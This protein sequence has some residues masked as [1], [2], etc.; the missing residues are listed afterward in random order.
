MNAPDPIA[1]E[2]AEAE[3]ILRRIGEARAGPVDIAEGALAL[4]SFDRP[5]VPW[6]RYRYHLSLLAGDLTE[7]VSAGWAGGRVGGAPPQHLLA[8]IMTEKHGYDGD[9]LTYED[10]QN[11]NLMR[12]IDRRRGLPVALGI[13]YMH[14][15]RAQGWEAVGL[16]F[17]GHFLIRIGDHGDRAVIDPFNAGRALT[18]ADLRELLQRTQGPEAKL[19]PDHYEAASDRDVL[20]RLQNN[21]KLRLIRDE[22]FE[23]AA[24]VVE[25]MLLFAPEQ[26]GLWREAGR[27]HAHLGNLRAAIG[28]LEHFLAMGQ[29]GDRLRHEAAGLLRSLRAKLN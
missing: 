18:P 9:R 14:A 11:A 13:L 16:T 25:A 19:A 10:L 5:R 3:A 28:A 22:Q 12:V 21:I 1:D 24:R 26:P 7:A 29:A 27:L 15:A 6:Q 4:A 17:P 2:R 23:R 8:Q 20:L